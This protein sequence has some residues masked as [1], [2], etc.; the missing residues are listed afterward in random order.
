MSTYFQ[1][2]K[3]SWQIYEPVF[4]NYVLNVL[5]KLMNFW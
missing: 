2:K 5:R 3:T 1:D 4:K